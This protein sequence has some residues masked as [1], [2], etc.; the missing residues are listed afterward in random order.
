MGLVRDIGG[1]I[2]KALAVLALVFL[3]FAHQPVAVAQVDDGPQWAVADLSFCGSGPDDGDAGH[4]PCHACRAGIADLP[5]APCV[6]E[7]A[8][9]AL[10]EA[11]FELSDDLVV[12]QQAYSSAN[13][14]APPAL[15]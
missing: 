13:P 14:R 12:L 15:V 4:A 5:P 10:G 9:V 1:E 6:A 3:S 7:P 8:Y 11:G 2:V